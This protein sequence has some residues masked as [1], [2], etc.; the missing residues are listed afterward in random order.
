MTS[1]GHMY[2]FIRRS[3]VKS[4]LDLLTYSQ[5]RLGTQMPITPKRRGLACARIKEEMQAQ[6]W[7]HEHL[8]AAIDYM[9][10]KGI[11]ARTFDYVFYHVD[12]AVRAGFLPRRPTK[13]D[14][15][16]AGVAEAV[17]LETDDDWIRKLC[18]ARGVALQRVYETW[19]SERKAAL[20]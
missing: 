12:A 15:L 16:E 17:A 20:T 5:Q 18:M 7:S 19:C 4:T 14:D 8:L 9:K 6:R 1:R 2:E 13:W 11:Q 10:S 3:D